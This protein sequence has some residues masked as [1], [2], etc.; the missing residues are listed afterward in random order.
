M[1][2]RRDA[3]VFDD[4]SKFYGEVLGVNR[5]TLTIRARDHRPRRPERLGQDDAHE[6]RD[7]PDPPDA[8]ARRAS[9]AISPDDPE[10]LFRRVG[11]CTQFDAFPPRRDR[12]RVRARRSSA[13]TGAA[14]GGGALAG[15]A[16]ERVGLRD[17]AEPQG[18]RL[19]QGDAPALRL[20]QAIA[21]DPQVLVLDEPLNGLDPMARAEVIALF[22]TAS[23]AGQARRRLEP[24]PPRGRPPRRPRRPGQ[25]GYVVAEGDDPRRPRGGRRPARCRCWSAATAPRALAARLFELDDAWSS[26]AAR[27]RPRAC[28]SGPRRRRLLPAA[29]PL[30][31]ASEGIE[32][33]AVAPADDDVKSVYRYLIEDA[34][35]GARDDRRDPRAAVAGVA[36]AVP[37]A[38]PARAEEGAVRQARAPGLRAGRPGAAAARAARG[39]PDVAGPRDQLR[40]L[41][42]GARQLLRVPGAALRGLP[43][44]RLDLHE[45]VPRRPPGPHAPLLPAGA[46]PARGAGRRQVRG[47]RRSRLGRVRKP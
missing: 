24:H 7:G 36:P 8:R 32:V 30:V 34:G 6:P 43:G 21:H 19:Q 45:P 13:C 42:A 11:Y 5:V 35:R 4:V 33:E 10:R 9:S 37:R 18:R 17:A 40:D 46:D 3:V 2:R 28:S 29:Q 22:A 44:V 31:L 12:A 39:D 1:T 38:L 23:P 14:R 20:A 41:H 16:L 27:G 26:R 25:R 15:E 47:G